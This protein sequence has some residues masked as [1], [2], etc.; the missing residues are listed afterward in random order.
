MHS[1]AIYLPSAVYLMFKSIVFMY[2][3]YSKS[4]KC[5]II[6]IFVSLGIIFFKGIFLF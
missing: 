2:F 4:Q 1:A 5:Y 3:N 6:Q